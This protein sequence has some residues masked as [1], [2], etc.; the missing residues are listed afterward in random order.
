MPV[1]RDRILLAGLAGSLCL[2]GFGG[3][4]LAAPRAAD[5]Q[6]ATLPALASLGS[7]RTSA[8]PSPGETLV[9]D[10]EGA[11]AR[12][13]IIELPAGSR[14]ADALRLAGGYTD[15]TDL[16]A[17]GATL[18]L[19]APL[20][21]GG[22][23]LVP[24]IGTTPGGGPADPGGTGGLVDLNSATPEELDALP[25][26]GPVTVQKIV[27]ARTERPF[28]TL[29][30]AVEREVLNNGQLEKIRDLATVR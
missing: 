24:A 12:P 8:S 4:L 25:G 21:D 29:E 23:V 11:V 19:A 5:P 3:W 26:I 20:T 14:V 1:L 28:A 7:G 17:A 2:V 10:V 15:A 18:N 16:V 27:A 13:G 30:E 9:V 22:Q 6:A